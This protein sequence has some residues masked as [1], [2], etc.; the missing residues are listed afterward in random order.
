LVWL[1]G[2][3]A[4][5]GAQELV[6]PDGPYLGQKPPG[7]TPEVFAPGLVSVPGRRVTKV[8]FSPDGQ[9]AFIRTAFSR[10]DRRLLHTRQQGGHWS[11]MQPADSLK[12]QAT[13][14]DYGEPFVAPD[15]R[16][17]FLVKNAD[18]WVSIRE[19]AAWAKPSP[20]PAP[21]STPSEEWHATVTLDGT[22]YFC[23][24]RDK[25]QGGYAIYRA[26]L[27]EGQYAQ[28]EKIDGTINSEYGAWDPF[29][30]PDESYL[31]FT[32]TRPGG[33]GKED[34][35]ISYRR[36]G[37]WSEPRNL[38]PAINTSESEY[39]SYVSPDGK[40]YFFSRPAGGSIFWVDSRAVLGDSSGK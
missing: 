3:I 28:V 17:L 21:V 31:V 1:L 39:G 32:S 14:S 12:S 9:E 7:L 40:Y 13:D 34:Q 10:A 20:L 6:P 24:N 25:P 30:A 5:S 26:R 18:I 23:S 35:Y 38:G 36:G 8:V 22:L 16:K 2:G 33:Y 4:V 29:I 11:A 37:G 19:N 15:G 27:R